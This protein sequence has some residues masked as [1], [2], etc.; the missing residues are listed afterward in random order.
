[1]ILIYS[2]YCQ[3]CN[4]LLET[5]KKHDKNNIVKKISVDLLRNEG[6]Q[7]QEIIH[8]VPALL[9]KED[10]NISDKKDILF[11][12]QVF[13]YLLLPNRGALFTIDNNTRLNKDTKDSKEYPININDDNENSDEPMA[14]SLGS[15]MSDNFSSL[16]EESDN[17]LKDKNYKWDLLENY[18]NENFDPVSINPISSTSDNTEKKLPS[19]EELLNKRS[20]DIL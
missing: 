6:Y 3:H 14:F 20:K 4:I 17:L 18:N 1:M 9:V 11:G 5:I 12:K 13:D 2:E 8:S 19:L 15:S 7:I 16:D 10:I